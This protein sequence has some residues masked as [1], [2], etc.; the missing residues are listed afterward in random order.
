MPSAIQTIVAS[1]ATDP[2]TNP[3]KSTGRK[4]KPKREFALPVGK[5]LKSLLSNFGIER[6]RPDQQK[7][8]ESVLS[9][10]DTLAIMPTGGGK[11]LCYQVPA[12]VMPGTT[13]VVSPLISLMKDQVE[14]L[15]E[16]GIE[17]EQMNSTLNAEE[18]EQ[19]LKNIAKSHSEIV[20]VTPERLQDEAFLAE[21][22]QLHIDLF[23]VDEAHCIS[24]WGHDFRP[25]FLELSK[26][27]KAL[28]RPPVLALTAT[29]TEAVAKHIY[30]QLGLKKPR[31]FNSGIYRPNLQYEVV[32]VTNEEEK[33]REAVNIINTTSGSGIIY[34]AT[35]K[36]VE[37]LYEQLQAAGISVIQ[38]HGKLTAKTRKENQELFM[39]GSR[40]VMV[41]TNA[42]GMGIDKADTRFVIHYQ[43]PANLEAYYQESG[44]AGRDG[45]PAR[46]I[47]LY[48][49]Q[50]KRVQ[51]FFLAKYYPELEALQMVCKALQ[52]LTDKGTPISL[53]ALRPLTHTLTPGKLKITLGLLKEAKLIKGQKSAHHQAGLYHLEDAPITPELLEQ[54]AQTYIERQERDKEALERMVGYAQSG[55]CR[56][57]VLMTYF[58]EADFEQCGGCDN[59]AHPPA[60]DLEIANAPAPQAEAKILAA[61]SL[62]PAADPIQVGIKVSVPKYNTG[63]VVSIAGEQVTVLFPDNETR[64]FLKT[65]LAP[66]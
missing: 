14:K 17:A 36:T 63:Q 49:M 42:F 27:I 16:A 34:A 45:E 6:L 44:R 5:S 33:L 26:A 4:S 39:N 18:A 60:A 8:I 25:A 28:G 38:Y 51:Q 10:R 48:Y 64:T 9:G 35:V 66:V 7:V 31:I 62:K 52:T 40:Q 15:E 50:D 55:F 11:S 43:L 1:T 57:K 21:L 12:L 37:A 23:V 53:D 32:H 41:A 47:L 20:F 3:A 30:T 59:C 46:C 54:I 58:G 2:A 19:A 56:W 22:Q 61:D 24:Q 13:I 29:A 65:Y